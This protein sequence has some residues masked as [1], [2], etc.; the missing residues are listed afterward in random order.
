MELE[1]AGCGRHHPLPPGLCPTLLRARCVCGH[2]LVLTAPD[3]RPTPRARV[4]PAPPPPASTDPFVPAAAV[5]RPRR[6]RPAP[7]APPRDAA[8]DSPASSYLIVRG[9]P[10]PLAEPGRRRLVRA[11][12]A[13]RP[14]APSA[15]VWHP[16]DLGRRALPAP[17]G[18]PPADLSAPPRRRVPRW[19]WVGLALAF[20]LSLAPALTARLDDPAPAPALLTSAAP[21]IT[22]PAPAPP[23]E[24]IALPAAWPERL[25]VAVVDVERRPDA[26]VI[27]G[28]VHNGTAETRGDIRLHAS[29]GDRAVDVWCCDLG[30]PEG[31][32]PRPLRAVL[33]PDTGA[34][35]AIALPGGA[36][37]DDARVVLRAS[38]PI[39]GM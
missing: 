33:P 4:T 39:D 34:G 19:P 38:R 36:P 24:P 27:H 11:G 30:A 5:T 28:H 37:V 12:D 18:R 9:R 2:T 13:P 20:A 23:P 10:R 15:V 29:L 16:A 1:C 32:L 6:A 14:G 3:A 22:A 26:T 31:A 35:F 25:A 21:P 7:A 8:P 17:A